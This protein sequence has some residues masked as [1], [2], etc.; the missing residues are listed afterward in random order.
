M[1]P[2]KKLVFDLIGRAMALLGCRDRSNASATEAT[3]E[4]AGV[5]KVTDD[6][7]KILSREETS[8]N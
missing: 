1:K 7:A 8:A 5:K 6:N 4:K 2:V 3:V